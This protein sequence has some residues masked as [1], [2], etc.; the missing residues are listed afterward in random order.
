MN[1]TAISFL[2][3]APLQFEAL[4]VFVSFHELL[5]SLRERELGE[6]WS[7]LL[8]NKQYCTLFNKLAIP[9]RCVR[10][11]LTLT[12]S[13]FSHSP[14]LG[15]FEL[16]IRY[17]FYPFRLRCNSFSNSHYILMYYVLIYKL[18]RC[19]KKTSRYL[20]SINDWMIFVCDINRVFIHENFVLLSQD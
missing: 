7:P 14:S 4:L 12:S 1:I 5:Y 6:C 13:R 2:R 20:C 10:V 9:Q 17:N 3:I 15:V 18:G 19:K 16:P 8:N 11:Y